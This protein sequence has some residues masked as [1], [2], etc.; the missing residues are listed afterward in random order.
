MLKE[1][2]RLHY[3]Y[4]RSSLS[5]QAIDNASISIANL[6]LGLP[7]WS[8]NYYH[9]F[10]Q[11]SKKKEV[12]TR[13]LITALSGRDKKIVIPK[14]LRGNVLANY[15]LTDNVLLIEN[16][17]GI[18]EPADGLEVGIEKIDVVFLP[19]LAFDSRG[20]RV[21]YGMG[22]YDTLLSGCRKDVVKVGLSM[23]EAAP[24]IV[25]LH[26]GDIAMDYCITPEKVY[27]F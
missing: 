7:I 5:L 17:W 15:L 10:L 16:Q 14:I 11:L 20:H 6:A 27:N 8:Y 4:L 13:Y 25:D 12:D 1:E 24:N 18:P 26:D 21:G 9:I 3:L 23:F 22:Y 2:L 19:L